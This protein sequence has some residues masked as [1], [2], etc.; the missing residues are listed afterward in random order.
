MA[1]ETLIWKCQAP[2]CNYTAPPS[3]G[4]YN[5]LVGHQLFHSK[6]GIPKEKRKFALIDQGTGEV[7]AQTLAEAR[8]KGVL[9]PEP[10]PSAEEEAKAKAKA[11]EEAKAKAKAEAEAK[12]KAAAKAK[13]GEKEKDGEITIPQAS[14][15]GI[16]RYTITL[17]AD[18]FTLFN[19]AKTCGLE[20]DGD[21]PFDE[22]VW[23]CIK[24]RFETD[25]Q[26]RLVLAPVEGE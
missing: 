16:F 13:G 10:P 18:A 9:E 3:L 20:K 11:E 23:D 2:D 14:S 26:V 1:E 6:Q 5:K 17:P 21:K 12:A 8:E 7:L 24:K 4:G 19:L 25:Y 15:S 22:F